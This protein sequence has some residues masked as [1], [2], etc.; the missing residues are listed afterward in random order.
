MKFKT[1]L[2]AG[3]A[4]AF[5]TTMASAATLDDVKAAGKIKCGVSQGLPGFSNP[6]D[7]G[8]WSGLDV[9]FC[10][11]MA[12]AVLGD[13]NAVEF[14][15]LS[16][17]VRF[18]ALQSG[19]IDVLSRNTTWTA[20]RDNSLGLEFVGVNYYDGQGFMVRKDLGVKSA[21]ELSGAAVCTNTGTTTE[22]NVADYF[23][24]QGMD[25]T[26]V[27]FE[28]ADEVVAAYDAGRCDVYTTDRSGLAAQRVKL[29]DPEAH[30]V[31]PEIISKEPLGPAV[32]HGDNQWGDIARWTL[33]AMINA[34]ELGIT[35]ANVDEMKGSDNPSIKRLLGTEGS[36][37]ADLGLG[38]DWAYNIVKQVGNYGEVYDATVGPNTPL[39]LDRGVNALWTQGGILYAAPVR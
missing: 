37:G 23:R 7:E 11:A 2:A 16:A 29:A 3:A 13:S 36:V 10:R 1:L 14:T 31:L 22:L 39:K 21:T 15:P 20:T 6:D 12:A 9:A 8:N 28:K 33:N 4:I 19:E 30:V 38:A 25:Y 32:R 27:A 24:A 35:S 5:S 17:K 18:T 34:E 26:V